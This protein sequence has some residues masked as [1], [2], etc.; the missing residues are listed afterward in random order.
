LLQGGT[1]ELMFW[2]CASPSTVMR[3]QDLTLGAGVG[4][5]RDLGSMPMLE[6]LEEVCGH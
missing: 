4:T 3:R 1:V 2:G 6:T 5:G